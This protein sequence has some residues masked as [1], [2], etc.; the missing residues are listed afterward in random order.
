MEVMIIAAGVMIPLTLGAMFI[1]EAY[2]SK[3]E[4]MSETRAEAHSHA[5]SGCDDSG[6]GAFLGNAITM[7]TEVVDA[8]GG[9]LSMIF[10]LLGT[11]STFVAMC[12]FGMVDIGQFFPTNISPPMNYFQGFRSVARPEMFGGGS[13]DTNWSLDLECNETMDNISFEF[14]AEKLKEWANK[15][16]RKVGE[17][18]RDEALDY[19]RQAVGAVFNGAMAMVRSLACGQINSVLYGDTLSTAIGFLQLP[20]VAACVPFMDVIN[21]I[22]N[23]C[24]TVFGIVEDRLTLGIDSMFN[25]ILP[26]D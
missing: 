6:F 25:A 1:G 11:V 17:W 3:N 21:G 4:A 22:L 20:G 23:G 15:A 24:N 16:I 9:F 18:L 2:Q 8:L 10:E 7:V 14:D 19:A 13:I 12:T 26:A 5:T